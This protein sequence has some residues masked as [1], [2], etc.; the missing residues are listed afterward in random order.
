MKRY[1]CTP[2]EV[3]ASRKPRKWLFV[4]LHFISFLQLTEM[5]R[6]ISSKFQQIELSFARENSAFHFISGIFFRDPI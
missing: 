5:L 3:N 4:Y 1:C 2:L 6:E